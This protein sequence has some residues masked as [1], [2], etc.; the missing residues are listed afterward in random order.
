MVPFLKPMP[1]SSLTSFE[2]DSGRRK[3]CSEVLRLA[4][5]VVQQSKS[6]VAMSKALVLE[7]RLLLEQTSPRTLCWWPGLRSRS[8]L[9]LDRVHMK[10]QLLA[11]G[12]P[13]PEFKYERVAH[14]SA[15]PCDWAGPR[16]VRFSNDL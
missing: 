10:S 7:S 15:L 11:Q 8:S 4:E 16:C 1:Y 9:I 6:I 14:S 5:S 2:Q 13:I 12:V 3:H